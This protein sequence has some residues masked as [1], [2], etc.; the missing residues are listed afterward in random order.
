MSSFLDLIGTYD[1]AS[2]GDYQKICAIYECPACMGHPFDPTGIRKFAEQ[3][4]RIITTAT[5]TTSTSASTP[6]PTSATTMTTEK[7][8][9]RLLFH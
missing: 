1:D 6:T 3:E 9:Y 7:P 5:M 4:I 8:G 2:V